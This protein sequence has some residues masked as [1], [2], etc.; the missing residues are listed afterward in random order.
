MVYD[1]LPGAYFITYNTTRPGYLSIE[2]E[3]RDQQIQGSPFVSVVNGADIT[4]Q[5]ICAAGIGTQ[6]TNVLLN[7]FSKRRGFQANR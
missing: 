1:E 6:V 2:I 4:A 5:T 3:A 7:H